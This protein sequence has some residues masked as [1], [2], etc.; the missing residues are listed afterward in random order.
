MLV[1]NHLVCGAIVDLCIVEIG[2]LRRGM[3]A[4]NRHVRDA[5]DLDTRFVCELRARPI[6][7]EPRHGEPA[8]ARNVFCVVHRDQTVGVAGVSDHQYTHIGC[9][10]SLDG[11]TLPDENFA[12]DPEQIFP[13]H[14]GFAGNAT[15]QQRPVDVAEAFIEISRGHNRL[16]QRKSAIVQFHNHAIKRAE[17]IRNFNQMQR[18]RLVPSEHFSGGDAKDKRVTNLSGCAGDSELKR[19]LH[20]RLSTL[21]AQLSTFLKPQIHPD[22]STLAG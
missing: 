4:P 18:E 21:N 5:G 11:L 14:A 3:I 12:V 19:R 16:Q 8:I 9:G 1:T 10:I 20:F 2:V 13:F 17:R 6:F 22:L 7:I 15:N